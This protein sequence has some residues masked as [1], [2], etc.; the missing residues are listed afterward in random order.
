MRAIYD[1]ARI[2]G[3]EQVDGLVYYDSNGEEIDVDND[4]DDDSTFHDTIQVESA[5]CDNDDVDDQPIS[6]GETINNDFNI[7]TGFEEGAKGLTI[8]YGNVLH[9][10][11]CHCTGDLYYQPIGIYWDDPE[12]TGEAIEMMANATQSWSL[13][14]GAPPP[15]DHPIL[16]LGSDKQYDSEMDYDRQVM[17]RNCRM[18]YQGLLDNCEDVG[19]TEAEVQAARA[20]LK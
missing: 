13:C 19:I 5:I 20:P 9:A 16:S 2:H 1:Q 7:P 18:A 4:K 10:Q 14:D 8:D 12:A 11:Y 3:M 15:Q 17:D 6:N